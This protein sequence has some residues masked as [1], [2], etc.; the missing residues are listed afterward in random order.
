MKDQYDR[1]QFL[2]QQIKN[3]HYAEAQFKIKMSG[4]NNINVPNG[5]K[6]LF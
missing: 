5:F 3:G 1:D 2:N 4:D 6:G